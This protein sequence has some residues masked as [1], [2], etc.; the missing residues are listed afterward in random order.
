MS[1]R[2]PPLSGLSKLSKQGRADQYKWRTVI[3][4]ILVYVVII[5]NLEWVWGILFLIWIVPDLFS[6]VTYFIEP[7]S[8]KD[9]PILFWF[10]VFS[11]LL[12]SIYMLSTLFIDYSQYPGWT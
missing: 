9:N 6:G 12:M 10:I 1:K 4:L 3:G 11:W 8:K 5:F 7:I 2:K